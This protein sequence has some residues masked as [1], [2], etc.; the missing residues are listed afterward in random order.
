MRKIDPVVCIKCRKMK[1]AYLILPLLILPMIYIVYPNNT[2]IVLQEHINYTP[3]SFDLSTEPYFPEVRSQEQQGSCAAW[4]MTYYAFGYMER[5]NLGWTEQS[6]TYLFSPAYTYNMA[7]FGRDTGSGFA[8]NGKVLIDWGCPTLAHMPYDD[9]DYYSWGDSLA[10]RNATSHK[11]MG[12]DQDPTNDDT[13]IQLIKA[14]LLDHTPVLF[15]FHSGNFRG[16]VSDH[17]NV[18]SDEEMRYTYWNHAQTIVGWDDTVTGDNDTGAFR[19]VNSWGDDWADGGYYWL[20][21]DAFVING[22][23]YYWLLLDDVNRCDK[24]LEWRFG[25]PVVRDKELISING[26]QPWYSYNYNSP[27]WTFPMVMCIDVSR[28]TLPINLTVT[29]ANIT[30]A[31]LEVSGIMTYQMGDGSMIIISMTVSNSPSQY[32]EVT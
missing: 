28:L 20:T 31:T 14:L 16:L 19:V 30:Y 29:G 32:L 6:D 22:A 23:N 24:I 13:V 5:R 12:Y 8:A 7:N 2:E 17:D 4:A 10:F 1:L 15:S 26:W 9:T 18:I 3:S 21:Y 27:D 11:I 25:A